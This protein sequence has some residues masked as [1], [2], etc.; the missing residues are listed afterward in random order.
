MSQNIEDRV[1]KV[2][3]NQSLRVEQGNHF[4][5]I[6]FE[7]RAEAP[8]EGTSSLLLEFTCVHATLV[9]LA[10]FGIYILGKESVS[11]FARTEGRVDVSQALLI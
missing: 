7:T 5:Y 6:N 10:A 2:F 8:S 11:L 1:P 9:G 3:L 4:N